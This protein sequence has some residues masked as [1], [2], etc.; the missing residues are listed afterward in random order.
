MVAWQEAKMCGDSGQAP[1][2]RADV[3]L[4]GLRRLGDSKWFEA[5]AGNQSGVGPPLV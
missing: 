3:T 1:P 5:A 2:V 4:A